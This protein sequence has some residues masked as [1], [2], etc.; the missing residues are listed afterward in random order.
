MKPGQGEEKTTAGDG[1]GQEG[2]SSTSSSPA[3]AIVV[4]NAAPSIKVPSELSWTESGSNMGLHKVD[5]GR[6]KPNRQGSDSMT[7]DAIRHSNHRKRTGLAGGFPSADRNRPPPTTSTSAA[8]FNNDKQRSHFA[9][10]LVENY[11]VIFKIDTG[12]EINVINQNVFNSLG[13]DVN[14]VDT[15]VHLTSYT[16]QRLNVTGT[17]IVIPVSLRAE[18]LKRLHYP[19]LG[20]TK[21]QLRAR[22]V[23]YWP[24]INNQIEDVVSKCETCAVNARS[25]FKE[26]M[27]P[28]PV[29]KLP[30]QKVGLDLFFHDGKTFLLCVDYFS[31]YVEILTMQS[32]SSQYVVSQVKAIF[33]RH[34][35]PKHVITAHDTCFTGFAF[36]E[37]SVQWEFNH[38][39]T[40]PHFSQ[41]NGMVERAIQNVKNIVKKSMLDK[42]DLYLAL[43]E[44]RNTPISNSIPSPA[45]ILF[46]RKINGV[47]PSNEMSLRPKLNYKNVRNSLI[48]RQEKQKMYYDRK[49]RPMRPLNNNENILMKHK[50]Q[51]VHGKVIKS[52]NEPRSYIV[53]SNM[54]DRAY[55]KNRYHIRPFP[56]FSQNPN[57]T[58]YKDDSQPKPVP[59]KT[60]P[61]KLPDTRSPVSPRSII[62]SPT[63]TSPSPVRNLTSP[64]RDRQ[65]TS[66]N[67]CTDMAY[68]TRSGRVVK[69]PQ[70]ID[71][72]LTYGL[73]LWGHSPLTQELLILQKK[74]L[75]IITS[76]YKAHCRPIFLEL[77]VLTVYS[78]YDLNILTLLKVTIHHF[79]VRDN[80]HSHH[81]RQASDIDLPRC[82]S[83]RSLKSYPRS[84]VRFFNSLP[85]HVRDLDLDDFRTALR[86][87]LVNRHLY[88]FKN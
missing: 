74:A 26:P 49:A 23:I 62:G 34:G 85:V 58:L 84:A 4:Q 6:R 40:S 54:S 48:S 75:R 32:M 64:N 38:V 15:D 7:S 78:Q 83:A 12:A 10:L 44:Y 73:V 50:N 29:P 22:N 59:V 5:I 72:H 66:P 61:V 2:R 24:N 3:A 27:L 43:L 17:A 67:Q 11:P 47:L 20:V 16:G 1:Q 80:I 13:T 86:D 60:S 77:G 55:V 8:G 69:A 88:S 31:K 37:F 53:K 76:G 82:R 28:H 25:N 70:R 42:S 81:T 19:H 65:V 79:V 30:W 52:R 87:R 57:R 56:G 21:T 35:I 18:M 14:L 51:W 9:E 33:S 68:K 36:K 39:L 41:A 63:R 71:F 45:E 46:S